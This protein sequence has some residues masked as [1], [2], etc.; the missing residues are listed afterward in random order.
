MFVH[1]NN[2]SDY[3]LQ[4]S[5]ATVAGIVA[6][7][8]ELGQPAVAITDYGNLFAVPEFV[9]LC[10][11][12][13]IKPIIGCECVI[14]PNMT[15]RDNTEQ[16]SLIFLCQ[17][18]QGFENLKKISSIGYIEGFYYVPRIDMSV[19]ESYN[20]G[21]LCVI[22]QNESRTTK[23]LELG[24]FDKAKESVIALQ[25]IFGNRLYLEI[26]NHGLTS[27]YQ[28]NKHIDMLSKDTG[29]LIVAGNDSHYLYQQDA[30]LYDIFISTGMSG[31]RKQSF[32]NDQY[33]LKTEEEMRTSL[34]DYMSA[35]D[36]TVNIMNRCEFTFEFVGAKLPS[37]HISAEFSNEDEFV[38]FLT[39]QGIQKKYSHI[40]KEITDRVKFEL[41]TIFTMGF[42]GYFLILWDIIAFARKSNIPVGLG[43]GSAAGS[44]VAYALGITDIDPL[45]YG[46]LFERFL[47]PE[48]ISMPDIDTDFCVERRQE[49]IEYIREKYGTDNVSQIITFSQLKPKGA[50]RDVAR[51]T[52][53]SLE[54]S[55]MI[56]KL[57]PF[58]SQTIAEAM[59]KE[60][61][62][63]ELREGAFS[64]LLQTT[65][66]IVGL[67][68]HAS[69]HA[70]GLVIGASA[71]T[72]YVP[73]YRDPKSEAIATQYSM[74]YLEDCGL[75][76]MDILGL[77][78]LTI[79]DNTVALIKKTQSDF[80]IENIPEDDAET[81][82]ML[83]RGD[84]SAVFQFEGDGMKKT[85]VKAPP[86]KIEDL[87]AL[88]ALYRPGPMKH[89]DEY[90]LV[91]QGKQKASYLHDTL[92]PIL[93]E[94]NGIIVYQEQ[95]MEIARKIA[96][97]T[98]AAAD[99]LRRAM[100]K[101]DKKEMARHLPLFVEGAEKNGFSKEIAMKIYEQ[102]AP[103]A[104]YG[105][106]KSHSAAYAVLA[107]Q[108]A[109]LKRHHSK[110]FM[111]ACI[112]ANANRPDD[113]TKQLKVC[114]RLGISIYPPDVNYS[115]YESIV[116]GE[117]IRY[118]L[119]GIKGMSDEFKKH[120]PK[121]RSEHGAYSTIFDCLE[122][123]SSHKTLR[124]L[125]HIA[126]PIGMFDSLG[127][128]RGQLYAN[129]DIL[130]NEAYNRI[131]AKKDHRMLLFADDETTNT[132]LKHISPE[133]VAKYEEDMIAKEREHLGI[134]LSHHPLDPYRAV[135]KQCTT[136]SLKKFASMNVQ[137][138]EDSPHYF[139]G[140]VDTMRKS[141]NPKTG[142][143]NYTGNV[144]D[145]NGE[146]PFFKSAK[147]NDDTVII[148]ERKVY[149]FSGKIRKFREDSERIF[150]IDDCVPPHELLA[151]KTKNNPHIKTISDWENRAYKTMHIKIA[152][153][154]S[155]EDA[156]QLSEFLRQ[157]CYVGETQICLHTKF[158]EREEIIALPPGL[159]VDARNEKFT[160]DLKRFVFVEHIWYE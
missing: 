49:V 102:L 1:L 151:L 147:I 107:Y 31:K 12:N 138:R 125:L 19:L 21:L 100:G 25:H 126:I 69:L 8:K 152:L 45:K 87:I 129:I 128:S 139:I 41:Q 106:N 53:V 61:K 27:E 159:Q 47:N 17:N 116:E 62:L 6:R 71:I 32:S 55:D 94:T 131:Q 70:A 81:F 13:G 34:Q 134:Y 155:S 76:K 88:N 29:V 11:K 142:K 114:K 85:L 143:K 82:E 132:S 136:F 44:I 154:F 97:Y 38:A 89:I 140:Y 56:A 75:V 109:Y 15:E 141:N 52:G 156:K 35:V 104:E 46:L 90:A 18:A 93:E 22:P 121:E 92:I 103:F 14:V 68:R 127:E 118:G 24:Q 64:E 99:L 157:D 108:T 54:D 9:K 146:I 160:A 39:K 80:C 113:L 57:I 133:E 101:I 95:V 120:I 63:K 149:G 30:A 144:E 26:Q 33:Y 130:H 148:E 23:C 4:K 117:G 58:E 150:V 28:I 65:E 153:G 79:I 16:H 124:S 84:S 36:E 110:C 48:R 91:Q 158:H 119:N 86:K 145:Y 123:L 51:A 66:K 73:L 50:L 37:F 20:E 135:W 115:E 98:L 60:P 10:E 7:V 67:H 122:R 112:N 105:F 40:N 43:R 3:S 96:G 111:V 74:K 2:H 72:D 83:S 42:S 137:E 77:R 78:T 5:T 59:I